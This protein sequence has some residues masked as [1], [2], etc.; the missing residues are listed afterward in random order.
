MALAEGVG[1]LGAGVDLQ[2]GHDHAGAGR[3]QGSRHPL[4]QAL[5]SSGD[6]G[7]AAAQV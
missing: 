1:D 6:E 5:G 3:G 4:A 7:R 2:V